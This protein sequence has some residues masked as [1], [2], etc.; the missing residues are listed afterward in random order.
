MRERILA[1]GVA[2]LGVAA[3]LARHLHTMQ[4]LDQREYD[5]QAR[6]NTLVIERT[7][8]PRGRILDSRG[9]LLVSNEPEFQLVAIPAETRTTPQELRVIAGFAAK[10]PAELAV[11]LD[12]ARRRKPLEPLILARGLDMGQIARL[13]PLLHGGLKIR[14]R[15]RR[16]YTAPGHASHI[17]GYVSE[18]TAEELQRRRRKGFVMGDMLGQAGLEQQYDDLLRGR[19]GI[20]QLSVDAMGRTVASSEMRPTRPGY[21]LKLTLRWDLQMVAEKA[22]KDTLSQLYAQNGERSSGAVVVLECQTGRVLALAAAPGYDLRPFARGI[23]AQEYRT[24]ANDPAAPLLNRAFQTAFSPGSTFKIINSSASLQEKMCTAGTIF[25]CSGSYKG[26]NCF[27]TGGHG[28]LT[29]EQTLALSC[30]VTYYIL[31]DRLGIDRLSKWCSRFGLGRPTGLDLPGETGGLLP[32]RAW[33]KTWS[34][35][36]F[37]DYEVINMGIGQ[38]DLLVSPL[39]MAVATSIVANGGYKVKPY[40]VEQAISPQGGI[41]FQNHPRRVKIGLNPKNLAS[42]RQGMRGAVL[43]GTAGA[44]N[45]TLVHVAG[46]TGTVESFPSKFNPTGRNHTWFV[47][48]APYEKPRIATVVFLEKSGGFGGSVAA[49]I[50]LKVI[51][52]WAKGE[53]KK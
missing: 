8:A 7:E 11:K 6:R 17:F 42:V 35:E 21:D 34:K 33:K 52:H 4:I 9:K 46:K 31:A 37:Q 23:T 32:S 30:D 49:P 28:S 15:D 36:P 25:Y 5:R 43:Y 27:Q 3:L 51:D 40:L 53:V 44:A 2:A 48:F 18:I 10:Q 41:G 1:V 14:A 26:H 38:G 13:T 50:A 39:Q 24:L 22:L 47:S 16:R 45:S 19:K 29:F 20:Q 12:N